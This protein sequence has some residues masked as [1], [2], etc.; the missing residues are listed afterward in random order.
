MCVL[1]LLVGRKFVREIQP[2]LLI[3]AGALLLTSLVPTRVQS[4]PPPSAHTVYIRNCS[5]KPFSF[6]TYNI[7]DAF[8]TLSYQHSHCVQPGETISLKCLKTWFDAGEGCHVASAPCGAKLPL[9]SCEPK[10]AA[11]ARITTNSHARFVYALGSPTSHIWINRGLTADSWWRNYKCSVPQLSLFSYWNKLNGWDDT[12]ACDGAK[13]VYERD[14][15]PR[16]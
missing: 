13:K 7:G 12:P 4:D 15:V 2:T 3:F 6:Q 14:I 5:D 9:N 10:Y 1:K 11:R 8:Q 16:Q